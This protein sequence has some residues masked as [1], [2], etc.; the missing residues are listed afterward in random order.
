MEVWSGS[1]G[2]RPLPPS[3][4]AAAFSSS[5]P[6]P[7][8]SSSSSPSPRAPPS[9]ARR[10]CVGDVVE[11]TPAAL[12]PHALHSELTRPLYPGVAPLPA[13]RSCG[14]DQRVRF[15]TQLDYKGHYAP[16][17][18]VVGAPDSLH[19]GVGS[20]LAYDDAAEVEGGL[21]A[22]YE[23][24]S[25]GEKATCDVSNSVNLHHDDGFGVKGGGWCE[26]G[27]ERSMDHGSPGSSPFSHLHPMTYQQTYRTIEENL[28][29]QKPPNGKLP[30]M[31]GAENGMVP[32]RSNN[33]RLRNAAHTLAGVGCMRGGFSPLPLD[34]GIGAG[35]MK[36]PSRARSRPSGNHITIRPKPMVSLDG[37]DLDS[38]DEDGPA[39][40][41][42]RVKNL[43]GSFNLAGD[44]ME[45]IIQCL[46]FLKAFSVSIVLGAVLSVV[47]NL[48]PVRGKLDS[49][50]ASL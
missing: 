44:T 37:Q 16:G 32:P 24:T 46:V 5:S 9:V 34:L 11:G 19:Q 50:E 25:E 7:S 1:R 45:G 40:L 43:C 2:A 35:G 41:T 3:S 18:A 8:S 4:G 23:R 27:G 6:S 13:D 33:A 38:T 49:F 28:R 14:H 29:R 21:H 31:N 22:E 26:G 47:R 30:A 39:G 48:L 10:T 20:P 42:G 17:S 36:H 15:R 12:P